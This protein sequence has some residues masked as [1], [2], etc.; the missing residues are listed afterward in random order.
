MKL[1]E[2]IKSKSFHTCFCIKCYKEGKTKPKLILPIVKTT[3][4]HSV[5]YKECPVLTVLANH[6]A[7]ICGF[8]TLRDVFAYN[9]RCDVNTRNYDVV[10]SMFYT[11]ELKVQIEGSGF[12]GVVRK[13][14]VAMAEHCQRFAL[15]GLCGLFM[16]DKDMPKYY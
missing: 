13:R 6:I 14:R 15:Y 9:A 10:S 3:N 8:G 11:K 7:F 2:L 12:S 1:V 5:V 4:E 16:F